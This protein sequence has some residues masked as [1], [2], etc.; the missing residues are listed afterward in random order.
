MKK[1]ITTMLLLTF[2]MFAYS[3]HVPTLKPTGERLTKVKSAA[4]KAF[5]AGL[6]NYK[7]KNYEEAKKNFLLAIEEDK[8]FAE[9]YINLSKIHENEGDLEKAKSVLQNAIDTR[10]K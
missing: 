10:Q 1:I 8:S 3:Q 5:E 2:G 6:E 4:V 7:T 9:A